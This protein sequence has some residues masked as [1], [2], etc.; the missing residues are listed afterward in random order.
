MHVGASVHLK[1]ILPFHLEA[2]EGSLQDP[3]VL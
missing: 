2:G 1:V 3:S